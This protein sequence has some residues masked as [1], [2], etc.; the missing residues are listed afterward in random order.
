GQMTAA[1]PAWLTQ[2][3]ESLLDGLDARLDVTGTPAWAP[4]YRV[5]RRRGDRS[6]PG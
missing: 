5:R 4:T 2:V 3:A 1:V 6:G